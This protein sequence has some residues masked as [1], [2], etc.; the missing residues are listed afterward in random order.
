MA[1]KPGVYGAKKVSAV[2]REAARIIGPVVDDA[3]RHALRPVLTAARQITQHESVKKALVLKKD[4][5]AP[6]TQPVHVVGGDPKNPDYRLLHLLEFGVD[7][8][9]QPKRKVMHPGHA[10][11]PFLTPAF[12]AEGKNAIRRFGERLGPA[13]EKQIARLARKYGTKK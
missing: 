1:R 8:H 11:Q 6:K 2:F 13:F 12:E 5:K 9:W 3:S 10:P 4:R 7:P